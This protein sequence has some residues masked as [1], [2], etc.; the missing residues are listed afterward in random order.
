MCVAARA[1]RA[2]R[3]A[4]RRRRHRAVY[5]TCAVVSDGRGPGQGIAGGRVLRACAPHQL[6]VCGAPR[7]ALL[8][9]LLPKESD[10]EPP[11]VRGWPAAAPSPL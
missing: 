1:D 11:G 2:D 8:Q 10:S 5:G 9:A 3:A 7:P 6:V 4:S